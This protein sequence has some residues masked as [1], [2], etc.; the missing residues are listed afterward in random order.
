MA[1]HEIEMFANAIDVSF[2]VDSSRFA[3]L[4]QLGISVYEWDITKGF[5]SPPALSARVT[6]EKKSTLGIF[7][8]LCFSGKDELLALE[9]TEL[10]SAVRRYGL[11]EETGRMEEKSFDALPTDPIVNLSAFAEDGVM[12]PFAQGSSGDLHSL[13]LGD[14]S[15]SSASF[16]SAMPW[17]ELISHK[18]DLTS[19]GEGY[20]AFG[21]TIN[22]SLY[23]NSRLLV[24]NCTSFLVTPAHLIFTT[25]THLLKFVHI[26]EVHGQSQCPHESS[27][28]TR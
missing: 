24:K 18:T 7:Q 13:A 28:L 16:P 19:Y 17:V 6:F 15:L 23:A 26:T 4:H 2:N 8:Q 9:R 5:S 10:G 22:G 3:V 14:A 11:V 20:I 27:L 25:T 1:L 12:H 21:L